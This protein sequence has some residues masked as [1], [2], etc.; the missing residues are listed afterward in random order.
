M[1]YLKSPAVCLK[2]DNYFE[3]VDLYGQWCQGK[4]QTVATLLGNSCLNA[5]DMGWTKIALKVLKMMAQNPK[6]ESTGSMGSIILGILEVQ[7]TLKKQYILVVLPGSGFQ[8]RILSSGL[9]AG[10]RR[11][12]VPSFR[13]YSYSRKSEP[14]P[15]WGSKK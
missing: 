15:P 7:V 12:T 4:H 14:R 5:S 13:V 2:F 10:L 6:T 11:Q 9:Q 8:L 3:Y 1:G